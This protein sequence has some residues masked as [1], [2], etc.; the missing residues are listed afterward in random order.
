MPFH[1]VFSFADKTLSVSRK[2]LNPVSNVFMGGEGE[3]LM[4]IN[5]SLLCW[6]KPLCPVLYTAKSE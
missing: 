4:T 6:E 2:M 3:I 5:K 1:D